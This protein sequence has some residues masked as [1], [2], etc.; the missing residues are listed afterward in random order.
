MVATTLAASSGFGSASRGDRF[1][2]SSPSN[3]IPAGSPINF[4]RSNSRSA[5]V[6]AGASR[7][8]EKSNPLEPQKFR[9]SHSSSFTMLPSAKTDHAASVDGRKKDAREWQ[10]D[11]KTSVMKPKTVKLGLAQRSSAPQ[12]PAAPVEAAVQPPSAAATEL[13]LMQDDR[14][15]SAVM[16]LPPSISLG[17]AQGLTGALSRL[18]WRPQ[19]NARAAKGTGLLGRLERLRQAA[20]QLHE[21]LRKNREAINDVKKSRAAGRVLALTDSASMDGTATLL[22]KSNPMLHSEQPPQFLMMSAEVEINECETYELK[23]AEH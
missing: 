11:D 17:S 6:R 7:S 3:A 10:V 18:M 13:A 16:S 12:S 9:V 14:R 15:R 1:T 8:T 19:T 21:N 2:P 4:A 5:L 22:P 23:L 20:M